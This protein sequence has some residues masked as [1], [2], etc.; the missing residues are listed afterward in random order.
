MNANEAIRRIE[1]HMRVHGI[2]E[3]PHIAIAEALN[4]AIS[5]LHEKIK[6]QHPEPLTLGELRA[7]K[8]EHPILVYAVCLD[9]VTGEPDYD[10]AEWQIFD[11]NNFYN[12]VTYDSLE[13]YGLKFIAYRSNPKE[14]PDERH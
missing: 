11:G 12:D 14:D 7:V 8:R 9:D 6:M 5:A 13:K 4:M 3:P 10:T 1:E 2:G